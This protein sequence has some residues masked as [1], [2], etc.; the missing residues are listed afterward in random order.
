MFIAD[1]YDEICQWWKE[2]NWPAVEKSHLPP[3]G[4]IVEDETVKYC[5]VWLY[6]SGTG[7]G[8]MEWLVSNP[9]SPLKKRV[10]A[11]KLVVSCILQVAKDAGVKTVF[12]SVLNKNLEKMFSNLGFIVTDRNMTNLVARVN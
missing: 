2:R 9:K 5:A 1:E 10:Q 3:I 11:I 7:F 12:T 8:S 4:L 6:L